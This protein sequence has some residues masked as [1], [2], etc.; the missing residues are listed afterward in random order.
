M[1][2]VQ[3]YL[4]FNH[5]DFLKSNWCTAF[6]KNNFVFWNFHMIPILN[7]GSLSLCSISQTRYVPDLTSAGFSSS[8]SMCTFF[9]TPVKC[10]WHLF[11]KVL[12]NLSVTT[13]I[14]SLRDESRFNI[15]VMKSWHQWSIVQ[16][17]TLIYPYLV[18]FTT[19]VMLK[20][21]LKKGLVQFFMIDISQ[22]SCFFELF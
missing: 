20:K 2:M 4:L 19:R 13:H 1:S 10:L 16:S 9:H 11:F 18:W 22:I 21:V 15:I 14:P 12:I 5:K 17:T 8:L 7:L 3:Y 6:C